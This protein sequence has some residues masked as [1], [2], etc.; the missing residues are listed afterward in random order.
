MIILKY[1]TGSY[2]NN[3]ETYLNDYQYHIAQVKNNSRMMIIRILLMISL[4]SSSSK[5]AFLCK[6]LGL[7]ITYL[8]F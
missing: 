6:F 1:G 4:L 7:N 3:I 2:S 8:R 5:S